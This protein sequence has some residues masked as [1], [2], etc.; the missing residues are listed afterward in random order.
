MTPCVAAWSTQLGDI[1][2]CFY[3]VT[4]YAPFATAH[5]ALFAV[6]ARDSLYTTYELSTP[7]LAR[8]SSTQR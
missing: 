6:Y 8:S 1:S 4:L 3:D 2:P 5:L 7:L